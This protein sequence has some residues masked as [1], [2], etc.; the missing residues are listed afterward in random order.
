MNSVK[1]LHN[2]NIWYETIKFISKDSKIFT[3]QQME[4][5]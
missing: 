5:V 1:K 3:V 4:N 2:G